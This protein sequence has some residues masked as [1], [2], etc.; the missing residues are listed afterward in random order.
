MNEKEAQA[1]ELIQKKRELEQ[2]ELLEEIQNYLEMP[3]VVLSF[4]MLSLFLVEILVDLPP[5]TRRI[6]GLVQLFIWV[7]FVIEFV[8]ELAVARGKWE[9]IKR[10]WLM[11]LAVLLPV[12]RVF[13]VL[14]AAKA[15]RSLMTIRVI[16]VSNRTI[17]QLG[18][19]LERRKLQYLLTVTIVVTIL[20]GA[21]MYFLERRATGADIT[22]IGGAMWWS[23]GTVTT[24]GTELFPVTAE[25]RVLAVMVMVFGVSVFT[26]F[27]ASLASVFVD[28][29]RA[30]KEEQDTAKK[31]AEQGNVETLQ[32]QVQ[33]L[34]EKLALMQQTS[35]R[36]RTGSNRAA[37]Q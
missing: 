32:A 13:R 14:R 31:N 36:S 23:A 22:T 5:D 27:A 18:I 2:N 6:I 37:S 34:E 15:V 35:G 28:M 7:V 21:G 33:A 8:V 29:D 11:T 17:S 10:N 19:L 26:Y 9:F 12:L 30:A 25:G 16:T 4:I 1:N 24:V 3:M 20:S